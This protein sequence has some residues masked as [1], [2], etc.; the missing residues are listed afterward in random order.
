[1]QGD[2]DNLF[3]SNNYVVKLKADRTGLAEYARFE[4]L[5][6][7][8]QI[9]T[10]LNHAWSEMAHDIIYKKPALKGFGGKLFAAIE[11]RLQKI[12]KD[13]LLPAGYEFQKA[14]DD[15]ERLQNGQE[16]FDR[17]ALRDLAEC[18]DNNARYELLE[19][20]RDYVLPN[21][22]DPQGAYPDI[23]E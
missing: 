9:Q 1:G 11:Q 21:Y 8:V 3:I 15:Y 16:L 18:T 6:C 13:H 5:W 23:K 2:S 17:G 19:R 10:T 12:M 4:G 14:L 22:N 7:E 20:F